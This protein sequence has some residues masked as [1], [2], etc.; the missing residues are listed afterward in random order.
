MVL[1]ESGLEVNNRLT[2]KK[3]LLIL[4]CLPMIGFGQ[5][6][7]TQKSG[8]TLNIKKSPSIDS[9]IVGKLENN[10][11]VGYSG[12]WVFGWI[13]INSFIPSGHLQGHHTEGW[14]S[15]KYLNAPNFKSKILEP[16]NINNNIVNSQIGRGI[17]IIENIDGAIL[18]DGFDDVIVNI[19]GDYIFLEKKKHNSAEI[20]DEYYNDDLNIK[21]F[22]M[23][24]KIYYE[25]YFYQGF[26]II[27]YKGNEEVIFTNMRL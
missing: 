21:V 12:E 2:L 7:T 1:L 16:V 9:E 23:T 13:K 6:I 20:F 5:E 4:L 24:S 26:V 14:V 17:P 25:S 11:V 19:K 27:N 8:S 22:N 3:L 18:V 15:S 10:T